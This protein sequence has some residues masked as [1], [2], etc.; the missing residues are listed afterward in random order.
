MS[1]PV[2]IIPENINTYKEHYI[3]LR[4]YIQE[5]IFYTNMYIHMITIEKR[6]CDFKGGVCGRVWM[7]E[8]KGD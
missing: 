3:D 5:H 7:A 8:K 2:P 1:S 4:G 6:N